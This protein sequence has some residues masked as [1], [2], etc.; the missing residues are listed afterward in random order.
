VVYTD[1]D[2]AGCPATRRSTFGYAIFFGANFV[3]WATKR[4]PIVSRCSAEGEYRAEANGVA[5]ASWMHQLL[6]E[7]HNP[8][9]RAT[10]FYCD[11]VSTVYFS[12]TVQHQRT[13]H[14]E[15]G[16]FR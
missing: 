9:Q 6:N 1:A 13:E 4:Q 5:E 15:I 8:I 11:N 14:V 10:L 12:N 7:L 3:S 2:W 16:R